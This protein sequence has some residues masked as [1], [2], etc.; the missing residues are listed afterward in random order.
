MDA[1]SVL[2]FAEGGGCAVAAGNGEEG[3][4][5][6]V[7]V[8]DLE[9]VDELWVAYVTGERGLLFFA[10]LLLLQLARSICT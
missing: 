3:G 6:L 7:S 10:R 1:N 8:E 4:V 2:E 5:I 9:T